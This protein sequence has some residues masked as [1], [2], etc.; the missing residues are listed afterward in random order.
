MI[1][2]LLTVIFIVAAAFA[3]MD[4]MRDVGAG[5]I[6]AQQPLVQAPTAIPS[7]LIA[8]VRHDALVPPTLAR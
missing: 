5:P 7:V 8:E 2:F 6:D 1:R 3:P 4:W